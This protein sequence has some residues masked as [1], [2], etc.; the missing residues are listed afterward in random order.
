M[1]AVRRSSLK[2]ES[3]LG[4]VKKRR[5]RNGKVERTASTSP[6]QRLLAEEVALLQGSDVLLLRRV[7]LLDGNFD[8]AFADDEERVSP[9]SLPH[10][11]I[12]FIVESLGNRQNHRSRSS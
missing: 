7:G 4:K 11:V 6:L 8:L 10:Y 9:C 12:A 5:Q 1:L 2:V 3:G